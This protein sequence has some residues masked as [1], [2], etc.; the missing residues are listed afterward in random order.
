MIQQKLLPIKFERSDDAVTSRSGLVLFDEFI[1]AFGLERILAR[2][3]PLPG[4]N[5]GFGAW[6]YIEPLVLMLYGGGRHIEDLRELREDGALLGA[7]QM[8]T[9]PSSSAYGDWLV[10]MGQGRGLVGLHGVIDELT[11][12]VLRRDEHEEYALWSDPTII[13]AEKREALV[14]YRGVR[15]YRPILTAFKEMPVVV[16]HR[17]WPGNAMGEAVEALKGAYRLLPAGKRIAHAALDSEFYTA[18]VINY[19]RSE[20]TTFTIVADKDEAVMGVIGVIGEGEWRPY[21]DKDGVKTDR[22]LAVTVHCMEKTE[23]F[24]LVV[25]RWRNPQRDLFLRDDYCYH[26]IATDLEVE[27]EEAIVRHQESHPEQACVW[28]YNERGQTEN[29]IKELKVGMGIQQLPSGSFEANAMYF[30]IGVLA[31]NLYVAQKYFVIG[32]EYQ[33]R[34][35]HSLRWSLIQIPG[36]LIRHAGRLI[37]KIAATVGKFG[38][39]MRM[40]QRHLGLLL[41]PG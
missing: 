37:L 32:E 30:A 20:G 33:K 13:E 4:S 3:M 28:R 34:T 16:W 31:Y 27:A 38:H 11:R 40:R 29:I 6:R 2:H 15:G 23:A 9:I 17:F 35:I 22:E 10:K 7:T 12:K 36:K 25:L 8:G 19:L 41:E 1:K 5:R 24:S 21:V 14:S 39:Y 18:D 26:A